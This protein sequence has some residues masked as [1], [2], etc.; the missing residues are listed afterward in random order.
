MEKAKNYLTENIYFLC[1]MICLLTANAPNIYG[2]LV[3]GK[4]API[5]YIVL[6]QLGLTFYL[7][8]AIFK[9]RPSIFII[10]GVLNTTLNLL[11]LILA[12]GV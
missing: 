4:T 3:H 12:L 10:S 6:L 9:K 1:G 8:D 5:G 2:A 7:L 11:V